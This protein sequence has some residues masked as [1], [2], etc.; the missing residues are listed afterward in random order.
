MIQFPI[1]ICINDTEY[2]F[3]EKNSDIPT[4]VAFSIHSEYATIEDY[5]NVIAADDIIDNVYYVK[6]IKS[7]Y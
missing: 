1:I 3:V 4:N 5:N 6:Y 7:T 2:K